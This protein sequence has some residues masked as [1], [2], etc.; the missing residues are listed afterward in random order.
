MWKTLYFKSSIFTSINSVRKIENPNKHPEKHHDS[1]LNHNVIFLDYDFRSSLLNSCSSLI[2]R[3]WVIHMA[4]NLCTHLCEIFQA[5]HGKADGA[6]PWE[7]Q[8]A[9]CAFSSGSDDITP[10]KSITSPS[11]AQE[12]VT[13]MVSCKSL[14][15]KKCRLRWWIFTFHWFVP[16]S[17]Y[18]FWFA[19]LQSF[20]KSY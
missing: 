6:F 4:A 9:V 17:S 14:G 12:W 1:I 16:V 5:A 15:R 11:P 18:L 13:R 3:L 7:P 10:H 8:K 2:G 20:L 19:A